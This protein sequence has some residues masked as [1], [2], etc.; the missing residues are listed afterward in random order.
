MVQITKWL[1]VTNTMKISWIRKTLFLLILSIPMLSE[2]V[3]QSSILD[4]IRNN[5][6]VINHQSLID[7]LHADPKTNFVIDA[8]G[9]SVNEKDKLN[10]KLAH[11]KNQIVSF[12]YIKN[13][14][15]IGCNPNDLI[16]ICTKDFLKKKRTKSMGINKNIA[17]DSLPEMNEVFPEPPDGPDGFK[18]WIIS[19]YKA[20]RAAKNAK[21]TGKLIVNFTVEKDG[22]LSDFQITKDTGYQT[23]EALMELIRQ[24]RSWKPGYQN[25]LAVKC[26][27]T[28]PLLFSAGMLK[29]E[30]KAR[31]TK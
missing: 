7:F 26:G 18:N 23:G 5:L 11:I 3:G 6:V 21:V 29:L 27:Y 2:A 22:S 4:S 8:M 9:Y 31:K 17:I 10:Q 1:F 19:N 25:G 28:F 30:N 14:G 20:P 16:V 15:Q 13:G 12:D 24:S